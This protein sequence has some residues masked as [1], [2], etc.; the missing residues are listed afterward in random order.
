ME[1]EIFNTKYNVSRIGLGLAALGRPG[2][3]NLGHAEDFK[4]SRLKEAM[5]ARCFELLNRSI[6]LGINYF[7][8]ARSYGLAEN[9]L[10]DWLQSTGTENIVV[11][12]KWGY[13]YT[14]NWKVDAPVHEVKEHS[15]ENLKTQFTESKSII[16]EQLNI[17]HIHSATLESGVLDKQEVLEQLWKMK[18]E[19]LII[20]LSVSGP[21]QAQVIEKALTIQNNKEQLFG[22]VQATYNILETSA[23]EQLKKAHGLGLGIIIKE[24]V[25]NGRLT[26]RNLEADFKQKSNF[27]QTMAQSHGVKMDALALAFVLAKPWVS[28]ALSGASTVKQ[29]ESNCKAAN[30]NLSEELLSQLSGLTEEANTY[31]KTRKNLAWN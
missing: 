5:K 6:E 30:I 14:A 28:T 22:S 9:F 18:E 15:I 1:K 17:Y 24:G 16:G 2:Y 26:N 19:G 20:G 13:K 7:D 31:W 27:L 23:E 4:N 21:K 25:A 11:G 3:I 8:A 12:S 10:A 29:L